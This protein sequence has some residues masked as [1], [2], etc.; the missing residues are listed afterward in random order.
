MSKRRKNYRKIYESYYGKIPIDR[1]GNS[2]HVHH[3]NGDYTDNRIE[4]LIALSAEDH[5]KLHLEQGDY[6]AA[7]MLAAEIGLPTKELRQKAVAKQIQ[8]G[9]HMS[10]RPESIEKQKQSRRRLLES[11]ENPYVTPEYK[12]RQSKLRSARNKEL[13]LQNKHPA[14]SASFKEKMSQRLKKAGEAGLLYSQSPEGKESLKVRTAEMVANGTHA[15]QKVYECP[16]CGKIGKGNPML[17]Y[18]MDSCK[19][20]T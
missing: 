15:S 6:S 1:Y 18:H 14:Q 19:H 8:E 4:N 5:Y 10:T 20:K 9:R 16:H 7:A 17:R 13:A 3:I 12:K 2:Y 11:P